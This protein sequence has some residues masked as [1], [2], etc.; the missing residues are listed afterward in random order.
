MFNNYFLIPLV[1]LL[2]GGC[3]TLNKEECL[4]ADWAVIGFEDG[5]LGRDAAYLRNHREACSQHGVSPKLAE[6]QQ[7]HA[8]GLKV[9][10]TPNNAYV[11][12][13][14]GGQYQ[15]VCP[16]DLEIAFLPAYKLGYEIHQLKATIAKDSR[17][18][19]KQQ[20]D[21][22]DLEANIHSKEFQLI[23]ANATPGERAQL[24]ADITGLRE[25]KSGLQQA[26]IDLEL[27]LQRDKEKLNILQNQPY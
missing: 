12:G 2:L 8:E 15:G 18:L 16:Y 10:C 1:L 26:I 21:M 23:N 20:A 25:R 17:S 13:L 7:G 4:S 3:A 9:F 5:S 27:S 19:S 14:E 24:L 22:S 6:Y 11:Y